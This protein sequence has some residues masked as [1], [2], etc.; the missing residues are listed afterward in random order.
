MDRDRGEAGREVTVF[1]SKRAR[2]HYM[3][4][5]ES[6]NMDFSSKGTRF[7]VKWEQGDSIGYS[8]IAPMI[9][10]EIELFSP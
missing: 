2:P 5:D 1:C 8:E 4:V 9:R 6:T 3:F 7:F 10:S